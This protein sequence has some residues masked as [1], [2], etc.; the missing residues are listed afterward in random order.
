MPAGIASFAVPALSTEQAGHLVQHRP[1]ADVQR[2]R[3][4]ALCLTRAPKQSGVVLPPLIVVFQHGGKEYDVRP[5]ELDTLVRVDPYIESWLS[6]H[7]KML[8][9]ISF[10]EY[11]Q[12]LN[13][14]AADAASMSGF[15]PSAAAMGHADMVRLLLAIHPNAASVPYPDGKGMLPLHYAAKNGHA[16][17][18][19]LLLDAAPETVRTASV[20][21]MLPVHWAAYH[22]DTDI[23]ELLLVVAPGT[24]TAVDMRRR[25]PLHWAAGSGN[26]DACELLLD[27]ALQTAVRLDSDGRTPLQHALH[28]HGYEHD[29]DFPSFHDYDAEYANWPGDPPHLDAAR[30]FVGAG[31][32]AGVLAALSAVPE[33]LP[34]FADF[35]ITRSPHLTSEEWTAAWSAVPA[36]CP[37]LLRALLAVLAHSTEQAGHL[38]QHLPPADVQRLRTAA[39]CLAR[40]QKQSGLFLPTA[41]VWMILALLGA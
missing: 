24:V 39:L 6:R 30:C 22:G 13:A 29:Y 14:H 35:F 7:P 33:A 20:D 8:A 5:A 15:L 12:Q 17:I 1:P 10:S 34:L 40:A 23:C 11:M 32:A 31:P 36:P 4:A 25:L 41:S 19:Q 9:S 21:G 38:V 26:T 37:G 2:L 28:G 18:C 3:T 27:R 16:D